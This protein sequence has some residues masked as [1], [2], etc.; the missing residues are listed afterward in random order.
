[1]RLT[2]TP[3]SAINFTLDDDRQPVLIVGGEPVESGEV[4]V[5]TAGDLA[6]LLA[7]FGLAT[8]IADGKEIP[9]PLD[10]AERVN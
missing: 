9:R 8:L 5:T 1:V 6:V 7:A 3:E 4:I 2:N 10:R